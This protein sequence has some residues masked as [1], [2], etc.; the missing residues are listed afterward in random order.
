MA[1]NKSN[2][3]P[4]QKNQNLVEFGQELGQQQTQL[5]DLRQSKKNHQKK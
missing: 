4:K 3:K 2:K 5:L 1:K